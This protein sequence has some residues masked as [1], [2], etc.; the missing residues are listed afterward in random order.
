MLGQD[1]YLRMIDFGI[2]KRIKENKRS[3]S[4]C[5]TLEYMAPEM[6]KMKGYDF[7]L[8]WWALGIFTYELMLGFPP[9]YSG[10]Q[11][12]DN[13]KIK[14]NICNKRVFFPKKEK[15]GIGISPLAEKFI[16]ELLQ[17]D[18]AKRLGA[19]KNFQ[20]VIDHEWFADI[21]KSKLLNKEIPMERP[22][23]HEDG[24]DLRYFDNQFK[25]LP[26]RESLIGARHR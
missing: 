16:E 5:G 17:K 23:L 26:A 19:N 10:N 3:K 21:D 13:Q 7:S 12:V 6:I 18:P 4:F 9:Y 2:A 11:Y 1:G 14:Q 8:D 25:D 15:H 20:E 22:S 24:I